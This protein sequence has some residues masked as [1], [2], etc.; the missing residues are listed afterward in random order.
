MF[1]TPK[2]PKIIRPDTEKKPEK[3]EEQARPAA[4]AQTPPKAPE[5]EPM[6]AAPEPIP[7]VLSATGVPISAK[8]VYTKSL[9]DIPFADI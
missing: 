2:A 3:A 4:P 5:Q 8:T 7:T 6:A 9:S 1:L